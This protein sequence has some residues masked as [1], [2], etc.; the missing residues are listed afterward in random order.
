MAHN[1]GNSI[2]FL[3]TTFGQLGIMSNH[4]IDSFIAKA[5]SF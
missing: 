5:A 4:D 2:Q 3:L 1:Q